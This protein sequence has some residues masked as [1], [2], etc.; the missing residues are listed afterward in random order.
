MFTGSVGIGWSGPGPAVALPGAPA[1]FATAGIAMPTSAASAAV[2]T[3][4]QR[5]GQ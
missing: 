2:S 3:V 1:G 5:R 4:I